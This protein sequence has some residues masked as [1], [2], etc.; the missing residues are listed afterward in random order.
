MA[1]V[2]LLCRTSLQPAEWQQQGLHQCLN[3]TQRLDTTYALRCRCWCW[4]AAQLVLL[5]LLLWLRIRKSQVKP[6]TRFLCDTGLSGA[7]W[8][9]LPLASSS[10][11]GYTLVSERDRLST[12]SLEVVAPWRCLQSL[13]PDAT[14]L[15][16]PDWQ[17]NVRAAPGACTH[18]RSM[19]TTPLVKA[20]PCHSM[21]VQVFTRASLSYH[22][23]SA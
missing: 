11:A 15:A 4:H 13:T 17:P 16:D 20:P 23:C 21:F 2:L 22:A 18:A 5:L 19:H 14:Q 9:Y 8:V 7:S 6:I 10:S 12:C 1:A 3:W